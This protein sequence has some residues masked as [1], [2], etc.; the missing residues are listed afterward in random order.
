VAARYT[1]WSKG[2]RMTAI[3]THLNFRRLLRQLIQPQ[4]EVLQTTLTQFDARL[5]S[6]EEKLDLCLSQ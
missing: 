5:K 3:T 2:A 4:L 1:D 6:M